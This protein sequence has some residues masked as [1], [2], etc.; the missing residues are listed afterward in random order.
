MATSGLWDWVRGY[1]IIRVTGRMIEKF[2][3]MAA[4][5]IKSEMCCK[6]SSP[7]LEHVCIDS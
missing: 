4:A 3:N 6:S 5:R 7:L 2:V 1:V